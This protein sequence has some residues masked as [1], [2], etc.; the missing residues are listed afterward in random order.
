MKKKKFL[1]ENLFSFLRYS[2]FCLEFLVMWKKLLDYK[3]KV[4]FKIYDVTNWL[5][6][7]DNTHINK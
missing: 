7:N 6:N 1:F 2:N 4:N 3:D 5:K